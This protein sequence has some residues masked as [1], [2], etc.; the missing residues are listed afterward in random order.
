ML[1]KLVLSAALASLLTTSLTP[2][3]SSAADQTTLNNGKL[4]DNRLMIPL[5][6]VTEHLGAPVDWH[7]ASKTV[8]IHRQD[9]RLFLPVNFKRALA[10]FPTTEEP[11]IEYRIERIDLDAPAQIV[12]GRSYVPLR[13]VSQALGAQV[14]W[15]NQSKQAT[16]VTGN[17]Q[18]V[19][20]PEQPTVQIPA[21]RQLTD[22]RLKQL[23]DKLNEV[24]T[25][26][27]VQNIRAAYNSF[28]T[29]QLLDKLI[30]EGGIAL[31]MQFE[32]PVSSVQYTSSTTATVTQ[33]LIV[34]NSLNAEENYVHDRVLL[35]RFVDGSWKIDD[36]TYAFRTILN[37]GY[38]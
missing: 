26:S 3:L 18:I 10:Y 25:L 29:K 28:F 8:T 23:S 14:D 2:A 31:E 7:A 38:H 33:S 19:V 5:R 4:M 13:F 12:D 36:A 21:A 6:A 32:P 9:S 27:S 1:K 20:R 15:N 11:G 17:Q 30:R 37:L 16:I 22:A 24:A 35:F 34:G